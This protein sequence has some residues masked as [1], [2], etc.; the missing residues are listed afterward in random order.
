M[1]QIT[2]GELLHIKDTLDRCEQEFDQLT[3]ECSAFFNSG[4]LEGVE[5]CME[6]VDA[7]LSQIQKE[8][9]EMYE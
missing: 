3:E 1:I 2:E 5:E 8:R 7:L 4:A 6:I 9:A